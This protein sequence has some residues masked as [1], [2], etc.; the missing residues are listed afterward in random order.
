MPA[1]AECVIV[2]AGPVPTHR[3]PFGQV[4]V[5]CEVK[6]KF[7]VVEYSDI[8]PDVARLT[9][10]SGDLVYS[11]GHV[12]IN[13]YSVGFFKVG[14]SSRTAQCAWRT[15]RSRIVLSAL[16]QTCGCIHLFRAW[17]AQEVVENPPH[18]FHVAEKKIPHAGPDGT[19]VTPAKNNGIKLESFIFDVFPMAKKPVVLEVS[20]CQAV[21]VSNADAGVVVVS[22]AR[23]YRTWRAYVCPP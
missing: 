18:V 20:A 23:Q 4:G 17:C 19:T 6:G 8:S 11:A 22:L 7:S 5:F 21:S 12:C 16:K 14:G 15:R 2:D 10:A 3:V 1:L 9:T 13:Y